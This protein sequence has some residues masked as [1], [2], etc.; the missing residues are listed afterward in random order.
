M[1]LICQ[2]T[3]EDIKQDYLP[4][5]LIPVDRRVADCVLGLHGGVFLPAGGGDMV[6]RGRGR[7]AVCAGPA[8][9]ALLGLSATKSS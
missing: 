8:S 5:Y 7:D 4:N 1:S 3:S 2:P 6:E 9:F